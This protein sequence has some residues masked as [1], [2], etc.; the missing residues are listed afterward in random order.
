MLSAQTSGF[1]RLYLLRINPSEIADET[2]KTTNFGLETE[3]C[4]SKLSEYSGI[5]EECY[6]VLD[7]SRK[8]VF[9]RY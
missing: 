7:C 5:L 4:S 9:W 6:L 3:M 1:L 2:G 8:R